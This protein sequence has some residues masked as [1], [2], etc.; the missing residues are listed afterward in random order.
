ME[1]IYNEQE[2]HSQEKPRILRFGKWR[3]WE[4]FPGWE[5]S[6]NTVKDGIAVLARPNGQKE[7]LT[8]PPERV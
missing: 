6:V 2:D 5:F 3:D 4:L 7:Q 1:D 8:P